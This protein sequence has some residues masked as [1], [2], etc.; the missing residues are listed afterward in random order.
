MRGPQYREA[1]ETYIQVSNMF[2]SSGPEGPEPVKY[3]EKAVEC[4]VRA[5]EKVIAAKV[6]EDVVRLTV[7]SSRFSDSEVVQKVA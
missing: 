7:G 4:F 5:D 6:S 2:L 3:L 1:G